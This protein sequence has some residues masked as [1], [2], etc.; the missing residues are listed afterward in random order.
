MAVVDILLETFG[1]NMAVVD[2]YWERFE[3]KLQTLITTGNVV[4]DNGS[5]WSLLGTL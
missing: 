1:Q 4:I 5:S 2:H 3:S